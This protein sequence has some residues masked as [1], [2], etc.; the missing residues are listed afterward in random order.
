MLFLARP[1]VSGMCLLIPHLLGVEGAGTFAAS[2][3]ETSIEVVLHHA[4][5]GIGEPYPR[6]QEVGPSYQYV[7][8][9]GS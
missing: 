3:P 1:R 5:F 4:R 8:I 9:R 7:P 2:E 6:Q